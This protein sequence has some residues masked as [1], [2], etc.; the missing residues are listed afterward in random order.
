MKI[1]GI[2]ITKQDE[3]DSKKLYGIGGCYERQ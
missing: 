1:N 2:E 3:K